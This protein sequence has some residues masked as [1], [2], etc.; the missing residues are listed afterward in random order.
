MCSLSLR[1]LPLNHYQTSASSF[2]F[3]VLP[4]LGGFLEVA[5]WYVPAVPALSSYDSQNPSV[6]RYTRDFRGRGTQGKEGFYESE[7]R[8]AA[9]NM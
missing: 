6:N 7:W 5:Q 2:S 9:Q 1:P 8:E 4:V 3:S